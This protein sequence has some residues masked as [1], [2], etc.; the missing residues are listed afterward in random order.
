[1]INSIQYVIMISKDLQSVM[2]STRTRIRT[3][4]RSRGVFT[5]SG[6]ATDF[7]DLGVGHVATQRTQNVAWKEG[8]WPENDGKINDKDR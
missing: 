3:S 4:T 7:E 2:T 6:S 5:E 1:M 8:K